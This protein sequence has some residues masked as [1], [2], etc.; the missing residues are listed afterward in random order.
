MSSTEV[1]PP[2]SNTNSETQTTPPP[3][4][5]RKSIP[6]A[7]RDTTCVEPPRREP[8]MVYKK[9]ENSWVESAITI[10]GINSK[11]FQ[12]SNNKRVASRTTFHETLKRDSLKLKN[13]TND[14]VYIKIKKWQGD[15]KNS[16]GD[17]EEFTTDRNFVPTTET[18]RN[19][20]ETSLSVKWNKN[21]IEMKLKWNWDEI[22]MKSNWNQIEM[23][24]KWDQK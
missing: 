7:E 2:P 13:V 5:K 15:V 19:I 4:K 20:T 1:Q 6:R 14:D 22:E 17:I 12:P 11:E 21:E 3:E 18:S 9:T 10:T 8:P 23:K 24:S 16:E